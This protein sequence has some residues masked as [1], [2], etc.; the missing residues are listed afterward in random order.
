MASDE[1][2]KAPGISFEFHTLRAD[3]VQANENLI[4]A[5]ALFL[6]RQDQSVHVRLHQLSVA[7]YAERV[8]VKHSESLNEFNAHYTSESLK[9]FDAYGSAHKMGMKITQIET[10]LTPTW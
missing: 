9:Q 2:Y 3:A 10:A 6:G 4:Y 5:A 1:Y 8:D 7:I